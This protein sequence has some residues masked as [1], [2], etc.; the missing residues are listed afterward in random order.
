[1]SPDTV[2]DPEVDV[3]KIIET[4]IRNYQNELP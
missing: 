1:M 3:R 4:Y 2:A